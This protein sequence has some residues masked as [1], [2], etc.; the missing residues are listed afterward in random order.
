MANALTLTLRDGNGEE[1]QGA[2]F[3]EGECQVRALLQLLGQAVT[4]HLLQRKAVSAPAQAAAYYDRWR[5]TLSEAA[6]G[7]AAL[8]RSLLYSRPQADWPA[9]TQRTLD[10]EITY[11]RTHP[12]R[13]P[14]ADFRAAGLPIGSGV[15]EAGGKELIKARFCRSGMRWKRPS[16]A[17]ILQLRAL[18][19]AQ[20]GDSFW[21]KV[22][23][24]AA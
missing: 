19:L 9:S 12:E 7:G 6:D 3:Y 2:P 13:L 1:I 22:V 20:Q 10:P 18:R 16:G 15:T 11:F 4:A 23:R 17:P 8:R 5:T 21:S 24:Y 14:Y